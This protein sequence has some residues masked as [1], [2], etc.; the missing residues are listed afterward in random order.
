MNAPSLDRLVFWG[1]AHPDHQREIK[2]VQSSPEHIPSPL[3]SGPLL[4]SI[5]SHGLTGGG[6]YPIHAFITLP[7]HLEDS[8]S[9]YRQ[10]VQAD[11]K[12]A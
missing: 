3:S 11:A 10:E 12:R 7:A 4:L 6:V 5:D 1:M 2:M 8:P 9:I